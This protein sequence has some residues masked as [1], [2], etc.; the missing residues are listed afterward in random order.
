MTEMATQLEESK[1]VIAEK[2][3]LI[4]AAEK[5]ATRIAEAT[6][7]AKV[8]ADLLSPL[9]KDKRELMGNLLESVKTDKLKVA[10]NKYL[11]TVLNETVTSK[12]QTLN[13][14]QKTEITGNKARTQETDSDAEIINLRK[15]AGIA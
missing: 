15:L 5:K 8:L 11:P 14:S 13:E 1:T 9:A 6:E 10:Y 4:E 3:A 12:A 7:R 2:E